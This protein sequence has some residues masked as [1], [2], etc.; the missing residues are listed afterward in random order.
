MARKP[1]PAV[2]KRKAERARRESFR[3]RPS[4]DADLRIVVGKYSGGDEVVKEE[5]ED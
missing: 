1:D 2:V 3:P 5:D 4:L